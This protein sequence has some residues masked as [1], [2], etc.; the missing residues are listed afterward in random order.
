[1]TEYRINMGMASFRQFL[2]TTVFFGTGAFLLSAV[3]AP[4]DPF[5]QLRVLGVFVPVVLCGSYLLAYKT[6]FEWGAS[7]R[8]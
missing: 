6:R 5:S 7:R 8:T 4:P 2:I 1:M 3:L